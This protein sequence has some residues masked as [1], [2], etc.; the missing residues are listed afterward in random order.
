MLSIYNNNI[1]IIYYNN[2]NIIYV[3]LYVM[4]CPSWLLFTM[5]HVTTLSSL[6]YW[7]YTK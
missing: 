6:D 2:N 5:Q 1:Y 3:M 4:R 7:A